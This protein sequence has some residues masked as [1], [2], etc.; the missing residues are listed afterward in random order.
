MYEEYIFINA[1][2]ATKM[3]PTDMATSD[4]S[5]PSLSASEA[6]P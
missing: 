1:A 5:F 6:A 3:R 2:C 4:E